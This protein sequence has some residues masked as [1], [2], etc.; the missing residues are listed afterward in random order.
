MPLVALVIVFGKIFPLRGGFLD[1]RG[2]LEAYLIGL[3][4]PLREAAA[5]L[6]ASRIRSESGRYFQR[7]W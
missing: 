2:D 1:D 3:S 6:H 7:F 5:P 4:P